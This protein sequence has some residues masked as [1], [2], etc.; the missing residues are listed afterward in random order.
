MLPGASLENWRGLQEVVEAEYVLINHGE[1]LVWPCREAALWQGHHGMCVQ[2]K[3]LEI[4][5]V[6]KIQGNVAI[7]LMFG[8]ICSWSVQKNTQM[9]AVKRQPL[10]AGGEDP[11]IVCGPAQTSLKDTL[12]TN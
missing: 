2:R 5:S 10:R 9:W 4:Y 3:A 11:G 7:W 12:S 6:M 8:P 1:V